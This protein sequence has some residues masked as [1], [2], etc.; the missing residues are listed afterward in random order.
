[1]MEACSTST[2]YKA[3][4]HLYLPEWILHL[5]QFAANLRHYEH[6]LAPAIKHT[7]HTSCV[8]MT[9]SIIYAQGHIHTCSG[10][11]QH[12]LRQC[13]MSPCAVAGMLSAS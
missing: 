8:H 9:Q 7:I 11:W 1:M 4:W 5:R 3:F 6:A 2:M 10:C 12:W 13:H